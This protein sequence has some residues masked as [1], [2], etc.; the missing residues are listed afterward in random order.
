MSEPVRL[1]EKS[2]E[3]DR[4]KE[5]GWGDAAK[6]ALQALLIALVVRT[7]LFQP[8]NIPSGSMIPTLLIGDY[9]FVSKYAY[10]YSRYSFPC[11]PNVLDVGKQIFV[12]SRTEVR[13]YCLPASLLSGRIFASPPKR[14]DV[15]VFKLPRDGQTDYIK[16]VIGLPGDRIQMREGRLYINGEITPR[17]PIAKAH[18]EDFYGRETDV[19]TYEETLPGGVKHTI[20]EI[21]GDTGFKDNTEVYEVPPGHYFMMG[22]NR[23]NSTDSRY[24]PDENGVGYVPFENLVGRAEVIFWSI[25]GPFWAVWEWPWTVRF[26]RMLKPVN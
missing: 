24:S 20:I 14:G 5:G 10:G 15:V 4:A 6:V 23:D 16:R 19:P 1:K 21:Q 11:V 2:D 26:G 12:D 3:A 8:F 13:S 22:D 9:L 17:Q 18:T 7:F 25:K